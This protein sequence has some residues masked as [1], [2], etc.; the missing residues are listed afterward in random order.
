MATLSHGRAECIKAHSRF[1][2]RS[3]N[4]SIPMDVGELPGGTC[5]R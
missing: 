5:G 4:R 3:R 1:A 2:A